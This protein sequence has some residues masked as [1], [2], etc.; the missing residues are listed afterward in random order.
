MSL[1]VAKQLEKLNKRID[2]LEKKC[3]TLEL[4]IKTKIHD[5]IVDVLEQEIEIDISTRSKELVLM[6]ELEKELKCQKQ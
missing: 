1:Y 6:D 3:D 4:I 5:I 2:K